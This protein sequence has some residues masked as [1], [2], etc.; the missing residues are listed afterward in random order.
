MPHHAEDSP[1]ADERDG[2]CQELFEAARWLPR[3]S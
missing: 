1:L 3:S 2:E